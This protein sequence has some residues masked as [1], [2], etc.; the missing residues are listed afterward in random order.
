MR[1]SWPELVFDQAKDTYETLHLWTQIV[2]KI[3]LSR[4]PWINHSWHVTLI[5]TPTGLTTGNL[6][7]EKKHFQINFD[8]RE[9]QLQILTSLG[10]EKSFPLAHH[11]V[12]AFYEKIMA[13]LRELGIE[14]D[15]HKVPNE[16]EVVIPFDQDEQHVTYEPQ[17]AADLH[18][19][20]LSVNE[21]LTRFRAE[22]VGKCSPVHFFW[23]SFDLAVTR[24]SGRKA[25]QHPGG[26]PHLPDRVAQEAYS[27]EVS[28]CGFWPGSVGV[29]FAAFYSY[30]Y[31][32][33]EGYKAAVVKPEAAYYHQTMG[34][35][36]LPYDVVRQA[37]DPA[38]MLLDFLQ[39]TYRAGADLADWDRENLEQ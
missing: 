26:V 30:M 32:E 31:P 36:I 39:S 4:M 5:V 34:E 22:F 25:P 27:H 11:S 19:V 8:F 10:E 33:P 15:I 23:G 37:D 20:L 17:H 18:T 35:F 29:P 9:H 16:L 6:P 1:N 13:A 24:F 3:K 21:V 2:G 38:A 12:A 7:A 28:S 14:I